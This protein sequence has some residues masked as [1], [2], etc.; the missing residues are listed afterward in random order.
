MKQ[1]IKTEKGPCIL[2]ARTRFTG[3]FWLLLLS[4]VVG[5]GCIFWFLFA[6]TEVV[7]ELTWTKF[8]SYSYKPLWQRVCYKDKPIYRPLIST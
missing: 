6:R 1:I 7:G 5:A 8:P 2:E 4:L 3:F